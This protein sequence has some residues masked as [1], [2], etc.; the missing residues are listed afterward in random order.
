[1]SSTPPPRK[2]S[3]VNNPERPAQDEFNYERAMDEVRQI[4]HDFQSGKVSVDEM[5]GVVRRA[6]SLLRQCDEMLQR[7]GDDLLRESVDGETTAVGSAA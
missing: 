4:I 7:V 2:R 3:D 5:H 1:M 6:K